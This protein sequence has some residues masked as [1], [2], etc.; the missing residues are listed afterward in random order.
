MLEKKLS[1]DVF[2]LIRVP[3]VDV[4]VIQIEIRRD[5]WAELEADDVA[6]LCRETEPRPVLQ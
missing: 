1:E 2:D 3:L 6:A 5:I 4:V